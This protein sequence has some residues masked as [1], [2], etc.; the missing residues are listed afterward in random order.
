MMEVGGWVSLPGKTDLTIQPDSGECYVTNT[1]S[2]SFVH[3]IG[4][5]VGWF[6]S[7]FVQ[8]SWDSIGWTGRQP[9][10]KYN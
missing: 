7:N 3:F 2:E 4:I 9:T 8:D 1:Y 6:H 10:G 5:D